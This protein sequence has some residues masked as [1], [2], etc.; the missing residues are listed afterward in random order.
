MI[1]EYTHALHTEVLSISGS[2]E[3]QKEERRVYDGREF[4]YAIGNA[5]VDTSCCGYGSWQYAVVPGFLVSWKSRKNE[6][7]HPVSDVELISDEKTRQAISKVLQAVES[8][9]RVQFW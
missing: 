5:I 8:V 1:K 4:L 2:Y 6:A 9:S 3:L 7:G